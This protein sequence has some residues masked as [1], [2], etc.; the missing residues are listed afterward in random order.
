MAT[1]LLSS[2]P[3]ETQNGLVFYLEINLID[4]SRYFTIKNFRE[5]INRSNNPPQRVLVLSIGTTHS[6]AN[7]GERDSDENENRI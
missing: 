3:G 6:P 1:L 7:C 5:K 2:I 4:P